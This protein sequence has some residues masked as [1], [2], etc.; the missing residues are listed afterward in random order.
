MVEQTASGRGHLPEDVENDKSP[1]LREPFSL[2]AFR[3]LC[4]V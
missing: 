4:S 3:G 1:Y 2:A